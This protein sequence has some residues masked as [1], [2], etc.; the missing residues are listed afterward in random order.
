MRFKV[1]QEG[2]VWGDNIL[3]PTQIRCNDKIVQIAPHTSNGLILTEK[4]EVQAYLPDEL[5]IFLMIIEFFF[6]QIN[7]N[8]NK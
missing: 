1:E 5:G 7:S 2:F 3:Y 8:S 6:I 4:K